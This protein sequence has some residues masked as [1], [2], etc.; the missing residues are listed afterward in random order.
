MS[1]HDKRFE[2]HMAADERS[3]DAIARALEKL[4]ANQAEMS[5]LKVKINEVVTDVSWL[6]K[7]FWMVMTPVATA[8]VIAVIALVIKK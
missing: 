3:F 5:D 8:L 7:F 4:V 2:D 1:E 6:K